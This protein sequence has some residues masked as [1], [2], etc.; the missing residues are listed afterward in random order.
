MRRQPSR[1]EPAEST[2][3]RL[4]AAIQARLSR[5]MVDDLLDGQTDAVS[6]EQLL[7]RARALDHDITAPYRAVVLRWTGYAFDDR[8][9]D[10]VETC[11]RA[12]RVACWSTRRDHAV[13]SLAQRL[14]GDAWADAGVWV[15]LHDA[16][17]KA[18]PQGE[19]VGSIGVGGLAPTLGDIP[20]S[21]REARQAFSIQTAKT[22]PHGVT[23]HDQLGITGLATNP[24]ADDFVQEWLA[25]LLHYDHRHQTKLTQTLAAHLH[26]NGN[27]GETAAALGIHRSTLRYRLYRIRELTDHDPADPEN[28]FALQLAT[29]IWQGQPN[30]NLA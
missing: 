7:R 26:H 2:E 15:A 29:R 10:T 17:T 3:H 11:A 25:P 16:M 23:N 14:D 4:T 27:Y 24:E 9:I 28:L 19:G 22:N 6:R 13:I 1:P 12:L 20:R 5:E 8:F 30:N 21:Y 18:L